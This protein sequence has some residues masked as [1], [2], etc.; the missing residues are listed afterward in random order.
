MSQVCCAAGQTAEKGLTPQGYLPDVGH[1]MCAAVLLDEHR[2]NSTQNFKWSKIQVDKS[3]GKKQTNFGRCRGRET[4]KCSWDLLC[5][6]PAS[7]PAAYSGN[8]RGRALLEG[9]AVGH[10]FEGYNI[11]SPVP[12]RV[13]YHQERP[14]IKGAKDQGPKTGSDGTKNQ[15][16]LSSVL[17][18]TS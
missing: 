5:P 4:M 17:F 16:N 1:A 15:I 7:Q 10:A 6:T 8:G 14:I 3:K 11:G 9:K 13:S 2:E 18:K 12:S